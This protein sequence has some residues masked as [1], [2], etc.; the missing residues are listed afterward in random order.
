MASQEYKDRLTRAM[1]EL[2]EEKAAQLLDFAEFLRT[3]PTPGPG[4]E[5]R[6]FGFCR[7]QIRIEPSFFDPLPDDI[8]AAFEGRGE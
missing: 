6:H 1:E 3:R 2:P 8:L 4:Q 5:D 7:G